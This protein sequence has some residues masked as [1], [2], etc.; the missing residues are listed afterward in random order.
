MPSSGALVM[1][2]AS[3]HSSGGQKKSPHVSAHHSLLTRCAERVWHTSVSAGYPP[4][5]TTRS[6]RRASRSTSALSASSVM[7]SRCLLKRKR[8]GNF[9]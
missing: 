6:R 2:H 4:L 3:L 9:W 5:R 1:K 8:L 7:P